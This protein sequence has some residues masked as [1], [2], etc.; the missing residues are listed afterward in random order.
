ME[1]D[2]HKARADRA[3]RW[4][5]KRRAARAALALEAVWPTVFALLCLL[6]LFLAFA[7]FGLFERLGAFRLVP[8]ALF[9]GAALWI[10][11]QARRIRLPGRNAA[12][13]RIEEANDLSH[14]PLRTQ[15]DSTA[16]G[17]DPFAAALWREHQRRMAD[18]LRTLKPAR[19][20]ARTERLDPFAFRAVAVLLL[21]SA[22]AY[23]LGSGGGRVADIFALPAAPT[24]IAARVDAWVTP[25]SYTGRPPVYLTGQN[26]VANEGAVN[27]PADSVL[28]VRLSDASNASLSFTPEG[29]AKETVPPESAGEPAV[30]GAALSDAPAASS[31]PAAGAYEFPLRANGRAELSTTLSTLGAWSF[32]VTPDSAPTIAF[33]GEPMRARSGALNLSYTVSDDYGVV[34]ARGLMKLH[35]AP[36]MGARPLFEPPA[37]KLSQPRRRGPEQVGRTSSDLTENPYA[38]STVDLTLDARDEAG[39]TAQTPPK[40]IVLPERAFRNP[41]ARA[42]IE[43]RRM[44]SLDANNAAKVVGLIDAVAFRGEDYGVSPGDY[45]ALQAVRSR[46]ANAE[47]DDELRSAV[48]FLWRIALGMEDGNL[49]DAEKRLKD[50]QDALSEALKNGASDE[51]IDKLMAEMRQAMQ[52]YMRELAELMKNRPPVNQQQLQSGNMQEIRPQDLDRMMNRIEDLAKSGSRDAAQQLLAEMQE[53]MQSLQAARPMQGQQQGDAQNPMQQQMDKLGEL[54]RRQQDLKNQTFNLDRQ[55]MQ[56]QEGMDGGEMQPPGT[57]GQ[58][59]GGQ[60]PMSEEELQRQLGELQKQQGQLQKD[61]QAL[62]EALKGM[63]M[64]PGEGFGDAGKAMG[65]A[66]GALGEG[67]NGEAVG[68]QGEAMEALRRGAR[69]MMQQM[70][71]AMGQGEGQGQGQG[72]GQQGQMNGGYGRGEQR[73]DRDPLGR[74]RSTQGPDFGQETEVP[75]EIDTQR[76]RRILD[77]IRKRLGDRLSPQMEREYLERLLKT[78]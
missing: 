58:Q 55:Q 19:P 30:P 48:D 64:E 31:A 51:E 50:A 23:S 17:D 35:D 70:Q 76:A 44:L 45:L 14:R 56:S 66:E 62:Q 67:Q 29:G 33:A 10:L 25:P 3:D 20:H 6:A 22:F 27:V 65:Q 74:P 36:A 38:G 52:E 46:I 13:A 43:Q 24:R 5:G 72:Q 68:R 75:D 12:E 40:T 8:L 11:W 69:D 18:K 47:N 61:L 34:E 1:R 21:V 2:P 63:G 4:N 28:S 54:L 16:E 32:A 59:G 41:A 78:P 60:Q 26:A 9:L 42:V 7:W 57:E 73:S 53:M 37:I 71:Q 15:G 49:S 39:Q 77:A